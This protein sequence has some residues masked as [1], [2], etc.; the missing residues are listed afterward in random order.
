MLRCLSIISESA[1]TFYCLHPSIHPFIIAGVGPKRSLRP[2][3]R[4]LQIAC[5][6]QRHRIVRETDDAIHKA[7]TLA[8]RVQSVRHIE[9]KQ[10]GQSLSATEVVVVVV[11][12]GVHHSYFDKWYYSWWSC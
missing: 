7:S 12:A 3:N 11:E 9:A 8:K 1:N 5:S 4:V 2:A 10:V 6:I